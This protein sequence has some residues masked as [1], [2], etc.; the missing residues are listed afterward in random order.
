MKVRSFIRAA[1]I[2]HSSAVKIEP[3]PIGALI[4]RVS[5]LKL[6]A[7][8]KP[9]FPGL[10]TADPS[11]YTIPSESGLS[12]LKSFECARFAISLLMCLLGIRPGLLGA[13]GCGIGSR[14]G[15]PPSENLENLRNRLHRAAARGKKETQGR[16]GEPRATHER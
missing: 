2:A 7:T 12:R 13:G 8:P 9:I 14:N 4:V 6:N 3:I 1:C 15:N 10:G 11:V 5:P 16:G